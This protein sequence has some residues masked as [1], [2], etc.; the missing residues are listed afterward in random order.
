M[1]FEQVSDKG[2]P[3]S[4][5]L[6]AT[7]SL[8][9]SR[10]SPFSSGEKRLF[11]ATA[12]DDPAFGPLRSEDVFATARVEHGFISWADGA[13]D[14]APECVYAN[15]VPHDESDVLRAHEALGTARR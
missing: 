10:A 6:R 2:A 13:I 7:S 4:S 5:K 12:L 15:G 14:V 8:A 3:R 11:D 9:W 1:R